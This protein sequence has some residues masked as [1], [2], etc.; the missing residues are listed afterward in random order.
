MGGSFAPS[1]R[2]I[3]KKK[4]KKNPWP[5]TYNGHFDKIYVKDTIHTSQ[6]YKLYFQLRINN[7]A[8]KNSE[9][10]TLCHG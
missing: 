1:S 6:S 4:K 7:L 3:P 10:I 8:P 5:L 9:L 2:L